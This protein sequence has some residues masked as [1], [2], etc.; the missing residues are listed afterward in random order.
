MAG[1][2]LGARLGPYQVLAAI[3]AGGMGEVYRARDGKL[4]RD[5]ALKVLPNGFALDPD[6]LARF[7]REAQ[8]LA[9]L[10]HPNIA[11]IYDLED[12]DG[13]GGGIQALVLE[14]VEGPTLADRIAQGP[15]PVEDALPIGR[16]IAEALEAA[17]E[18]GIVHRDLKP[19]NVKLRPD[20]TVKVL[21]FGLAKAVEPVDPISGSPIASPTITSPALTQMGVILGTAA[22]MSP[23]QVKG[24]AADKRSDVWAFGAV[25]Y[26]MLSGQRAFKGEDVSDTLAA[27]LREDIDLTAL[28]SSTP[29]SVRT[30]V[31]RCLD[32]DARRRLR[33]LGEARI[34][35]DDPRAAASAIPVAANVGAGQ[36]PW[37]GAL[38][39]A[40]AA[41]LAAAIGGAAGW[42]AGRQP[43]TAARVTRFLLPLP[44]GQNFPSAAP[45]SV[46]ALST[47]GGEIVYATQV[48]L[49]RRSM[50]DIEAHAIRGTENFEMVTDPVFSPDGRSLLFYAKSDQS[51][52]RIAIGGGTAVTICRADAPYGISWTTDGI[53]FGQGRQG[54][55]RVSA[56]GG[57]PVRLV[58]A[59][60]N[61]ELHG[62]QLLPG[63]R[64][65]LYTRTTGT[66]IDRWTRAQIVVRALPA[67]PAT[68]LL[69]GATDAKYLSSG[70]LVY[71]AD[72]SLFAVPFDAARLALAGP[73]ES[74]VEGVRPSGGRST[75]GMH[76]SV[77]ASGSLIYLPGL[78]VSTRTVSEMIV[79]D[80]QGKVERLNLPPSRFGPMR[81]S[82]D[83]QQIAFSINEGKEEVLYT[84][85]LSGARMMQPLFGGNSRFPV[86]A[87]DSKRIAFQSDREGDRAIWLATLGGG[88]ERLTRPAA[89]EAHVPETWSPKEEILL[90]T[91]TKGTDTSLWTLS[92]PDR[93]VVPF[94]D[95]HSLYPIGA[96]F[97]PSGRWV[98]YTVR[99]PE[100]SKA[101]VQ[102]FPATGL[103][104]E[105]FVKGSLPSPHKVA[106]SVDGSELFYVPRFAEFE[107]VP[108]TFQPT[109]AF[110]QAV[111]V[112]RPFNPGG[113]NNV[114]HFDVMPNG[115][116]IG[117]VP[118]GLPFGFTRIPQTIQVVLNW[119]EELRARVPSPS[120]R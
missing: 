36:S 100:A 75:G 45:R 43:P 22:Y 29:A 6:R 41:A 97:H 9:S 89:G 87:N 64:H 1:L 11:A 13:D 47:D 49:F 69:E 37:R 91:I 57:T 93:K 86:W 73:R 54:I 104:Y 84:Y 115:K 58:E 33:D 34:V 85:D 71:G 46:L 94:G 106:W 12:G 56:E 101:Y 79:S 68:T 117:V 82:P 111:T 52:K 107:S 14:L 119:S 108:V 66:D 112:T 53:V 76:F 67:G 15:I 55:M 27:V 35:L 39:V 113:P 78:D 24:R 81:A 2:S 59:G 51:I 10:N 26:E 28:P 16:Q 77:S 17:H 40:L 65:L 99:G 74:M 83:G 61:E 60:E 92:V 116:F 98:A 23:E 62:P 8:V 44:E 118:Q 105:L 103:K 110:G 32:R 80:R 48:G 20:G 72:G 5:V 96:K 109:F 70:H 63:G 114:G 19:A 42:F 38:P 3:G 18:Q 4:A 120:S 50:S 21:D 102:P 88:I 90:F 7:K 30:L 31:A 25:L 95:V